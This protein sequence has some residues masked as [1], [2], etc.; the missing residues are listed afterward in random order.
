MIDRP[1][2][3]DERS[4][5][6]ITQSSRLNKLLE[7]DPEVATKRSTY[8]QAYIMFNKVLKKYLTEFRGQLG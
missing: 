1:G 6:D 2:N 4:L 7:D 3:E 5:V 8:P